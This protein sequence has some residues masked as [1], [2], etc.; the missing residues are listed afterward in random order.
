MSLFLPFRTQV[1]VMMRRVS[2]TRGRNDCNPL[3]V[4][5]FHCTH[6]YGCKLELTLHYVR[7]GYWVHRAVGCATV[8]V[9]LIPFYTARQS[10]TD[11]RYTR[12]RRRQGAVKNWRVA[13]IARRLNTNSGLERQC[14]GKERRHP[15]SLACEREREHGDTV[16]KRV[17]RRHPATGSRCR[18]RCGATAGRREVAFA[19]TQ[20]GALHGSGKRDTGLACA[21]TVWRSG[22]ERVDGEPRE[23]DIL[24]AYVC[25]WHYTVKGRGRYWF[26]AWFWGQWCW[27]RP[28]RPEA[29]RKGGGRF[30]IQC[31]FPYA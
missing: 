8:L 11:A 22:A 28:K 17:G 31:V 2:S 10:L 23:D 19:G 16:K 3:F 24:A 30:P 7:A 27:R 21:C 26:A 25:G 14:A 13:S 9:P 6:N 4:S 20:R 1:T 29:E 5:L 12:K 15:R 18:C